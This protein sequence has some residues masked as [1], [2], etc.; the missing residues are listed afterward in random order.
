VTHCEYA[1]VIR[2]LKPNGSD[3][4]LTWALRCAHP[5][6]TT[7]VRRQRYPPPTVPVGRDARNRSAQVR[8]LD[9][10]GLTTRIRCVTSQWITIS[11]REHM[12][13]DFTPS[14]SEPSSGI[15]TQ[16]A[17]PARRRGGSP[18]AAGRQWS[19]ARTSAATGRD[20][21]PRRARRF[22]RRAGA[23]AAAGP[24]RWRPSPAKLVLDLERLSQVPPEKAGPL[25]RY[26]ATI[27]SQRGDYRARCSPSARTPAHP[28]GDL[29]P[30]ALL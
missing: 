8:D 9:P 21:S 29:R 6:L 15:R 3:W 2:A 25:Q 17:V 26:A 30:V 12:S 27:Q 14:N 4:S 19:W 22:L 5:S 1:A 16:Q 18:K 23:G 20:R 13:S 10:F 28:R 24:P 11:V 7:V